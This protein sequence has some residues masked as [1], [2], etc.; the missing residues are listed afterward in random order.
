MCPT[1]TKCKK[2]QN[3]ADDQAIKLSHQRTNIIKKLDKLYSFEQ[4]LVIGEQEEANHAAAAAAA[5]VDNDEDYEDDAQQH[6]CNSV[7]VQIG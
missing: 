7:I 5:A 4:Q 1:T 2:E 3:I 6:Y